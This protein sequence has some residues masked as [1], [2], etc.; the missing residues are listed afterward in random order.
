M[1]K[2]LNPDPGLAIWTIV[3]FLTLVM[4]LKKTAWGPL[5]RAIEEREK[6]MKADVDG[7]RS[8][9]DQAERIK[10]EIEAE[11][12]GLQN[13]S[14]EILSQAAKEAESLRAQLKAGAEDE[15]RKIK[16]KTLAELADER[17]RLVRD[18]R[19][20]VAS[21]TVMA[22]ERLM[23]KTVDE[24]VQKNVLE[25]FFKDLDAQKRRN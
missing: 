9:R 25:G 23:G 20:E 16:E 6:R 11:M 17:D 3:T 5:L 14:R 4:I 19:K 21:L 10:A 22:A 8:A 15:A 24:G 1:D 18:L 2:L 13:K 12:A 7:A